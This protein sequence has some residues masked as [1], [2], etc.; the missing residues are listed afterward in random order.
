MI[1]RIYVRAEARTYP[2]KKTYLRGLK[3]KRFA[4]FMYGLKPVP[5]HR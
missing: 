2:Q 5:T 1:C 4:G 3:A